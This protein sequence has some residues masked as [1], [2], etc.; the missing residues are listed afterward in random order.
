MGK[1]KKH[2]L[3]ELNMLEFSVTQYVADCMREVDYSEQ[4]IDDYQTRAYGQGIPHLLKVS[5]EQLTE[6]NKRVDEYNK[7]V[8][9][10]II[11][12]DNK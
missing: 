11:Q 9:N 6:C 2:A 10:E 8:E 1:K 5:D 7:R 3:W 4:E 12:E